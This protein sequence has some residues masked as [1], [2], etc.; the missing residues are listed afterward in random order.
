MNW[1]TAS[2]LKAQLGRLWERGE[3]LRPLVTGEAAYPLRLTFKGPGS[4]ELA[5]QFEPVRAWIAHLTG[6]PHIRIDWREVNH[7]VLGSQRLPQSVWV[8]RLDD[9]LALIGR[10]SEASRFTEL[11]A[12]TRSTRPELLVWIG[13]Q[14]LRVVELGTQWQRLLKVVDWVASHP[15]PGVYLRQVDIAG[16]HSKFIEGHKRVLCELLDLALPPDG[17]DAERTGPGQFAARYGFLDKPSRIRFRVLDQ[18]LAL[19][20]GPVLPD[21]TLDA[22][23]FANLNLAVRRVFI[24]ENETNFLAFP[25][26]PDSIVV[27]GAGYGWDALAGAEWLTHRAIHYW[28]DI[29]THGFAI[30]DQLRRSFDHVASFLMDRP[31]LLAHEPLWG[32]E[33]D[34]VLHDLP[35][36][37]VAERALYDELRDNR[38]RARLRLEQERVAFHSVTATVQGIV[39]GSA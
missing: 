10:R 3:L 1:T 5:E 38:I 21:V 4:S 33:M 32:E 37:T 13:K 8:E 28:G 25:P 39:G 29:D 19:L 12:L 15:R 23:S 6:I 26:A 14:P 36:L 24:T 7:R 11:L 20:R 18:R 16:V 17:I 9:A 31:T 35:R 2:D 22:Q 27:F 34:Q 30:L